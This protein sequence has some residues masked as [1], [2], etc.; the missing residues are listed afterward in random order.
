MSSGAFYDE[1]LPAD[2]RDLIT[3]T[4]RAVDS[5]RQKADRE[6]ARIR[7]KADRE[8]AL[9]QEKRDESVRSLH[10]ELAEKLK[11]LQQSY[12]REGLLDEALAIRGQIRQFRSGAQGVQPAP[13][14]L[15]GFESEVG[16]VFLFEL[17]G[18]T[19]GTVWGTDIYTADSRLAAAAVHAGV[20]QPG[21]RGVVRVELFDTSEVDFEGSR[22]N[23]VVSHD[24]DVYE[25][26]FRISR[27]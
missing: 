9:L 15:A 16:K 2:A 12:A 24:W 3:V 13:D 6:I 26:G 25:V 18:Q 11:P 5:V 1:D 21:E 10:A 23:N 19:G 14:N 17:T 4:E 27:P 20:L 7:Q 22:R 8:I